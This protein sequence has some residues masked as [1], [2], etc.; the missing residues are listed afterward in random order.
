LKRGKWGLMMIYPNAK[1]F[2][3]RILIEMK[4]KVTEFDALDLKKLGLIFFV[5]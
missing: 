3:L 2:L 4:G 5:I 1:K